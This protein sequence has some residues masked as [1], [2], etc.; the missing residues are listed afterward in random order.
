MVECCKPDKRG[1]SRKQVAAASKL[2]ALFRRW[3][4]PADSGRPYDRAN[5]PKAEKEGVTHGG[6]NF[7]YEG[8]DGSLPRQQ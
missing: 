3:P 8:F 6:K 4:T 1:C 7:D 2:R 5:G